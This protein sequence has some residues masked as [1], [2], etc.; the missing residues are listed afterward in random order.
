[1]AT[2]GVLSQ[3]GRVDTSIFQKAAEYGASATNSFANNLSALAQAV[4]DFDPAFQVNRI[5]QIGNSPVW[6][7]IPSRVG[8]ADVNGVTMVVRMIGDTPKILGPLP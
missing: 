1:M 2:G 4:R 7:S 6:G 3:L 8:I 5:G